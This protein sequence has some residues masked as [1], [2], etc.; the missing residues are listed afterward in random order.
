MYSSSAT[1]VIVS[2]DDG[3]SWRSFHTDQKTEP[4]TGFIDGDLIESY[5][6]L[7]RDKMQEVVHG[8]QVCSSAVFDFAF[9][10]FHCGTYT[11]YSLHT[12]AVMHQTHYTV[13]CWMP[14]VY[15][16]CLQI[17]VVDLLW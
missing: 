8:L 1:A 15:Q 14:V 3:F 12:P 13:Q 5:L 9:V 7:S 10:H 6:D 17:S 4:V 2:L 11:L 16:T